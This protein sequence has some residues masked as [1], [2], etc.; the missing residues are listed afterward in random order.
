MMAENVY[1]L[2]HLRNRVGV[3]KDRQHAG[4][5]LAGLIKETDYTEAM[6]LAVPAGGVPV[7]SVIAQELGLSLD[8]AVVSKIT[9]PWNTEAGYGAVAFDGSVGLNDSLVDHFKLSRKDIEEGVAKT[10][11]KVDRRVE[12][13]RGGLPFPELEDRTVILVDDGL[14]SGFTMLVA[15]EAVRRAKAARVRIAVP[16][17]HLQSVNR[18]AEEVETLYCSNI[19]GGFSFA[20]AEAYDNWY[21]VDEEDAVRMLRQFTEAREGER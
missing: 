3:F 9:L 13:F 7:A 5:V 14:A 18:L 2:R 17:G 21:D 1:E 6:V 11:E 15:V 12:K 16:T 4:K 8:V 19:R 10:F 20:V